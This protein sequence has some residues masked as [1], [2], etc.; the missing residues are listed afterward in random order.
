L[1]NYGAYLDDV[2]AWGGHDNVPQIYGRVYA[3]L[4]FKSNIDTTTQEDVKNQIKNNLSENLSIMSIDLVFAEAITTKLVLTTFFNLDPDLTSSTSQSVE[5]LV[6]STINSF[7]ATNLRKF[8]KVFRRSNLLTAIDALDVAILNSRMTVAMQREQA[9]DLN[10]SATYSITFPTT[11]AEP[12]D[13]NRVITS[14]LFTINSKS[15]SIR[16][17]LNSNKL[18]IVDQ[19][20]VIQIDNAGSYSQLQGIVTLVGFAPSAVQ[21]TLLKVNALPANQGTIRPLRNYIL[22]IDTGNSLSTAVID[23]QNTLVT[24]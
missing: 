8:N 10:Q 6:Q 1:A 12:D 20:G 23:N 7:F 19:D 9:I 11:L 13:V 14:S 18:E 15:C 21:G 4:K 17:A 16:N 3:G 2:I 24:L 22:D 5:N